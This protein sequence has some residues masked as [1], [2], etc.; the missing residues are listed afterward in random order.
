MAFDLGR[1]VLQRH[2]GLRSAWPLQQASAW[3]QR[4]SWRAH[5]RRMAS[6]FR[7]ADD[8]HTR[9]FV[10]NLEVPEAPHLCQPASVTV[11]LFD[12]AG[13]A[14]ASR[15]FSISR[16]ASLVLE[17]GDVLRPRRR[18]HLPSGQVCIDFEGA[19]L[20]SARAYL[21][22]YNDQSLTSSHEKFGLTIPAVGG[23]WSVP[24]VQDSE[25]YRVYLAV[26]NLDANS[27]TS[28]ITIKDSEAHALHTTVE[29]P[30]N[31]SRFLSL[32]ELFHDLSGF[33]HGEPGVLY[34]GNNHQP[35]MYY[36][37]VHNQR[38]ATWRVQH[39]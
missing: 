37:F 18:G 19:Q 23:Y 11:R 38:L 28:D 4:Q 39:L 7:D 8:M 35:A 17:L 12:Q 26:T 33:L 2:P 14:E 9:L 36:Y 22:W 30:P 32:G 31:G 29:L 3:R 25:E 13:N 10:S 1:G 24:D 6:W 20:G 16:N 21:H 15:R 34:F 27:Y 5:P